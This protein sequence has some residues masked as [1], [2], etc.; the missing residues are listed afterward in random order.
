MS[1]SVV[2]SPMYA[3]KTTYI[4]N[5]AYAMTKLG[6]KC[7]LVNH[8]IDT[9]DDSISCHNSIYDLN[10]IPFKILKTDNLSTIDYE[11]Y[12]YIFV[13]EFQ[14]FSQNDTIDTVLNWVEFKTKVV[15]AGLKGDYLNKPFGFMLQMIPHA[16]KIIS[17]NSMCVICSEMNQVV[18]APFSK[19]ISNKDFNNVGNILVGS[20]ESYIPVCRNHY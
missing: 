14:F 19:L 18:E 3:G 16:D 5:N 1:L 10:K 15:V 2:I 7:L 6:F 9:R 8:S 12:D 11:K 20:E 17:M 4:I 13:D